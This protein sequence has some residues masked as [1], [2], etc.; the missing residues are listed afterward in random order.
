MSESET[1][2]GEEE[3][4]VPSK[5]QEKLFEHLSSVRSFLPIRLIEQLTSHKFESPPSSEF[6]QGVL[7]IVDISGFTRLSGRY[8]AEGR[9]GIDQL[10][11][12]INGFIGQLVETVY[13]HQGDIIKFAGDAI[14]CLFC[15]PKMS[16]LQSH[17]GSGDSHAPGVPRTALGTP[18]LSTPLHSSPHMSGSPPG[19]MDSWGSA[20]LDPI[21]HIATGHS[22]GSLCSFDSYDTPA[23]PVRNFGSERSGAGGQSNKSAGLSVKSVQSGKSASD[24]SHVVAQSVAHSDSGTNSDDVSQA[25]SGYWSRSPSTIAPLRMSVAS[26]SAIATATATAFASA[27]KAA[28]HASTPHVAGSVARRAMMCAIEMAEVF[29]DTLTVHV[30]ISTGELCFAM[31][32]GYK[33]QYECLIAGDCMG[34]LSECLNLAASKEVVATASF[35]ALLSKEAASVECIPRGPDHAQLVRRKVKSKPK[36][37]AAERRKSVLNLS[38][39][40]RDKMHADSKATEWLLKFVP[41]PVSAALLG[42]STAVGELREVT[43]LFMLWKGYSPTAHRDLLT[44]QP[45]FIKCQEILSASGGFLRQFLVDDKGCVLIACWGVPTACYT[46]NACRGLQAASAMRAYCIEQHFKASFG[47]TTGNVY[48]GCVGSVALRRE[49]AVIGDVVNL[50]ARLMGKAKDS[51]LVD[52]NTHSRLPSVLAG[53][54][55]RPPPIMVKGKEEAVVI[56][57]YDKPAALVLE[58]QGW[59]YRLLRPAHALPLVLALNRLT[60]HRFKSTLSSLWSRARKEA[61]PGITR[62]ESGIGS[63]KLTMPQGMTGMAGVT[64]ALMRPSSTSLNSND[65]RSHTPPPAVRQDSVTRTDSGTRIAR[66]DSGLGSIRSGSRSTTGMMRKNSSTSP[67]NSL[68]RKDSNSL[69]SRGMSMA[70]M[71]VEEK[72][73]VVYVEGRSGAGKASLLRWFGEQVKAAAG[74]TNAVVVLAAQDGSFDYRMLQLLMNNLVK[75]IVDVKEGDVERVGEFDSAVS[76]EERCDMFVADLVEEVVDAQPEDERLE[77][78]ELLRSTLLIA[79]DML[80]PDLAGRSTKNS[81]K[82]VLKA[83]KKRLD[84]RKAEQV[85]QRKQRVLVMIFEVLLHRQAS[86]VI[87]E[88]LHYADEQSLQILLS[89]ALLPVKAVLVLASVTPEDTVALNNSR[90]AREMRVAGALMQRRFRSMLL[91]LLGVDHVSMGVYTQMEIEAILCSTCEDI[92]SDEAAAGTLAMAVLQISGGEAFWVKELVQFIIETGSEEFQRVI[93]VDFSAKTHGPVDADVASE[94]ALPSG[95]GSSPD[96]VSNSGLNSGSQ[97][98]LSGARSG[99]VRRSKLTAFV[100][101]R[102]ES[103]LSV[104]AQK[105]LKVACCLGMYVDA[106]LLRGVLSQDLKLTLAA[107]METLEGCKWVQR[108]QGEIYMFT[109]RFMRSTIYSMIPLS[110]RSTL[111]HEITAFVLHTHPNQGRYYTLLSEQFQQCDLDRAFEFGC[112]ACLYLCAAAAID[113]L[114]CVDLLI[115]ASSAVETVR[116]ADTVLHILSIVQSKVHDHVRVKKSPLR[117]MMEAVVCSSMSA[118][119]PRLSSASDDSYK[120][121]N[122]NAKT[123]APVLSLNHQAVDILSRNI[124]TLQTDMVQRRVEMMS[125]SAHSRK[126][127]SR[128]WQETLFAGKPAQAHEEPNTITHIYTNDNDEEGGVSTAGGSAGGSVGGGG[129]GE[130]L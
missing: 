89:I 125:H 120:P 44:L 71:K 18:R 126:V 74:V 119:S 112:K 69:I 5:D 76:L 65:S 81:V 61:L 96:S 93:E 106:A 35:S 70:M 50:S 48:C 117:R 28:T 13:F 101:S 40:L 108:T 104:D 78:A 31:L 77:C 91:A 10:Q 41:K 52:E 84:P 62:R 85:Q 3:V 6:L 23:S 111:H 109:N 99:M 102:F 123:V 43:T 73:K 14:I 42:G 98:Y 20:Q 103:L 17:S 39:R 59:D 55:S 4:H 72:I 26:A 86:V 60:A 127:H 34:Q 24:K 9:Q 27:L 30:G 107:S 105:V 128:E 38:V 114:R 67:L 94:P 1:T 47:L 11:A 66:T 57:C 64:A 37:N 83:A 129:G 79:S 22:S 88:N 15:E 118:A 54:F 92:E 32:G 130:P 90:S 113:G 68:I 8:C 75:A 97:N 124:K 110:Q 58:D 100:V 121:H 45:L 29:T 33:N 49:Y 82:L 56:F 63:P 7:L 51:L 122:P 53:Q 25:N 36:R 87:I 21:R 16:P 19:S 115:S 95:L 116:D 2:F 46:D 12:M 80:P